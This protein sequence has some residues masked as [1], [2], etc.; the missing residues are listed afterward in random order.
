MAPV[1]M[2]TTL[3]SILTRLPLLSISSCWM[4][5]TKR[6]SAWQY[7]RIATPSW[8]RTLQFQTANKP[9]MSG[10]FSLGGAFWKC[11]SIAWPP[12][13]NLLTMLKPY[14]SES[15]STPTA[16]QHE[17][18]PPTQSQNGKTLAGSIPKALVLSSAVEHAAT[19]FAT[20][21]SVPSS[22]TSHA[23]TVLA[24]SI[25]SAVVKVLEITTTRVVSAFKPSRPRLASM[26]STFARNRRL[27]PAAAAAAS[28]SVFRA[29]KTNSTP[30]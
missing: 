16:D 14:C 9:M 26:G 28:G 6:T 3:P 5:G 23:L 4:C 30:R 20:Q 8:P 29:S 12:S 1:P 22:L 27:R 2:G 7:G 11:S 21:S 17:K 13:K 24:F 10:K 25:V 15:P 18:R 19:C